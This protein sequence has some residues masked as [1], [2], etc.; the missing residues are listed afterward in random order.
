MTVRGGL[1][2]L[3]WKR[4]AAPSSLATIAPATANFLVRL[5]STLHCPGTRPQP[6]DRIIGDMF[7]WTKLAF[8]GPVGCIPRVLSH[9][10]LFR[11]Q[12]D[13]VSHI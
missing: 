13:N 7:Y 10:I 2:A 11:S 1:S 12:N 5:A 8:R 3:P 4:P 6:D 9:Y